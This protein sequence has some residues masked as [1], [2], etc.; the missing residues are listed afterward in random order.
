ME[1]NGGAGGVGGGETRSGYRSV[2]AAFFSTLLYTG[3]AARGT[4]RAGE[5]RAVKM[6]RIPPDRYSISRRFRGVQSLEMDSEEMD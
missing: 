1:F 2:R 3:A 4:G 6:P 5:E